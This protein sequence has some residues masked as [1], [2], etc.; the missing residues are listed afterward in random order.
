MASLSPVTAGR[1]VGEARF[2][3]AILL[4][5]RTPSLRRVFRDSDH[6]ECRGVYGVRLRSGVFARRTCVYSKI[7][8]D[9]PLVGPN[10]I[11]KNSNNVVNSS[12]RVLIFSQFL[13]P[14]DS[15]LRMW[16][17]DL[18]TSG[19]AA[20]GRQVFFQTRFSRQPF[21]L[22]PKFFQGRL[23]QEGLYLSSEGYGG[24]GSNLGARLPKVIFF[25]FFCGTSPASLARNF[26][27]LNRSNGRPL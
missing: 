1:P 25:I 9:I 15:F 10:A 5:V 14:D 26:L 6:A 8:T 20:K 11:S 16:S 21:E 12:P 27:L 13:V 18:I 22:S 4:P 3:C 2:V 7:F 24:R 23:P 19:L 17:R